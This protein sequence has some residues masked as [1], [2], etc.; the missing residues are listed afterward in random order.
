LSQYFHYYGQEPIELDREAIKRYLTTD[1]TWLSH[2]WNNLRRHL[3]DLP[4]TFTISVHR[5][6]YRGYEEVV[7]GIETHDDRDDASLDD[8]ISRKWD[9]DMD[10]RRSGGNYGTIS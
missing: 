2:R 8:G 4:I 7:E 5:G 1:A 10:T 9:K 3:S 6:V